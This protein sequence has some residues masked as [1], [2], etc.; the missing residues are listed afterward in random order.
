MKWDPANIVAFLK[1][2]MHSRDQY[3]CK[4]GSKSIT[5]RRNNNEDR[6]FVNPHRGL[7]IVADGVGG[8]R[9]GEVASQILVNTLPGYLHAELDRED[10]TLVQDSVRTGVEA[11][12]DRMCKFQEEY[13]VYNSMS[14]TMAVALVHD[15]TLYV[16]HVGDSR[17]YLY[18]NGQLHRLTSDQTFV[19]A[20]VDAGV[21][22]EEQV[23]KHPMRNI[24]L[25]LVGVKPMDQLPSVSR[26]PVQSGDRILLA[27]D[28]LTEVVNDSTIAEILSGKQ[29][30]QAIA[31]RLVE[32]ATQLGTKDNVTCV[33]VD[34][35]AV[36]EKSD[37][38]LP[39]VFA[40]AAG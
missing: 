25:N 3:T 29:A 27:T 38:P 13:P 2:P 14:T 36:H 40:L 9:G 17:I 24:V 18:S 10:V 1:R 31:N 21:I 34:L 35:V 30:P 15:E 16:S 23:P 7:F 4:A 20:M 39:D 8:H 11:A 5:G 32:T 28:G 37:E 12:R 33:V 26:I 6:C 22:T 19:Q